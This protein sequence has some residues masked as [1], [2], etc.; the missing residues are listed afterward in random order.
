MSEIKT[1]LSD[2]DGTLVAHGLHVPTN[3]VIETIQAVQD[4]GREVVPV[5][6]RPHGMMQEL[7][8]HI[9]FTGLGVFDGG[10]SIIDI[11]SGKTVW[12]NWLDVKRLRQIT[13]VLLPHSTS[14]DFFPEYN[15]IPAATAK[16]TDARQEAPYVFAF[17]SN[18]AEE[19]VVYELAKIPDLSIHINKGR[20]DKPNEFDIQ[21]TDINA[22]KFH[23]VKALRG[24]THSKKSETLAIGDGPNDFPLFQNAGVRVAMG[25]AVPELKAAADYEVADIDHDGFV[26]AMNR[27]VLS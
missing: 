20:K 26:E 9:G 19:Q 14:I 18:E 10:A 3:A 24:F 17:V 23:G 4:T 7:F 27:F 15:E 21:V 11:E 1:V 13:K 2:V 22:D 8:T 25:N 6:G 16:L 5:T 12:K